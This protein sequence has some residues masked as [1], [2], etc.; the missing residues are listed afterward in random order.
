VTYTDAVKTSMKR[1]AKTHKM[2]VSL[3]KSVIEQLKAK[4]ENIL[5]KTRRSAW[6]ICLSI[7]PWSR[8]ILPS[9]SPNG[10]FS[11]VDGNT[12]DGAITLI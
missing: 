8:W 3:E 1:I 7:L 4:L 6:E 5:M 12:Y 9:G 11:V 2:D 10:A